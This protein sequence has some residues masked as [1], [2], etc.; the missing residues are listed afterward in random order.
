MN[1]DD[2]N[3]IDVHCGWGAT[4]AARGW[5]DP[6]YVRAALAQRG[7]SSAFLSSELGRRFDPV[8]GN[9]DVALAAVEGG[10][11][12]LRGWLVVHPPRLEEANAQ[13]RRYVYTDRFVGMA[14]Y[15]DPLTGLPITGRDAREVIT[16]FRRYAKPILIEAPTAAA[17]AEVV[18][19]AQ[20]F[21]GV[22]FIAS[23]MGGEEWREAVLMAIKPL[24][25]YLDISGALTPDRLIHAYAA[26][27]G[28]RKLLFAS[29]APHTDP[30]AVLALLDDL[31]LPADDRDRILRGNAI[32]LFDLGIGPDTSAGEDLRP[33]AQ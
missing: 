10:E 19:I 1:K 23:G 29:G 17:M 18:Q 26:L 31:T 14:L 6:A 27:N 2:V 13:M 5:G 12:D 20:D 16:T 25:L 24:N 30:A 22:R 4:L 21:N 7:I 9:D 28:S 33:L 15:P 8:E 3:I 32:R 11:T